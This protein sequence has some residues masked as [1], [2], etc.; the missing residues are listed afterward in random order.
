MGLEGNSL[1]G[2]KRGGRDPPA[3]TGNDGN[4]ND[5]NGN[6]NG[7]DGADISTPPTQRAQGSHTLCGARKRATPSL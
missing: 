1:R 4:G 5:G 2:E 7:N 3:R 6:G